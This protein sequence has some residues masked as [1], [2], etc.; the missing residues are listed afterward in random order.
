MTYNSF[1]RYIK[2]EIIIHFTYK[3]NYILKNNFTFLFYISAALYS[4]FEL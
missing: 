1:K 4:Y 3:G 2:A